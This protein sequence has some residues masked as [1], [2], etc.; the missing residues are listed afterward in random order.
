MT[1]KLLNVILLVI[2][3]SV[4]AFAQYPADPQLLSEINKIKAIDNHAHPLRYVAEGSKPDDE[5][6][7]LP[8]E[9]IDPFP[10]PLR[11]SPENREFIEAW[12]HFYKYNYNDMLQAHTDELLTLKKKVLQQQ[13]QNFPTW[14]LDQLNIETT[15]ANRVAMGTGLMAPRFRWVSF[16]DALL[17]PL[18]NEIAK[19]SNRDYAGFYP[20]EEKLLK[21]YLG[22]LGLNR[23]PATLNEYETKVVTATLERQKAQGVIA[24]KY[25]AA[26]LRLLD[27]EK[28]DPST[29]RA[30]YERFHSGG[31]APPT[32]HKALQD[33]L[34]YYI[35]KEA[36]R[37]GLGSHLHLSGGGGRY[38]APSGRHL[39]LV[40]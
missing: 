23:L 7:A 24:L 16:V 18:N 8:L 5:D 27:F 3:V 30:T 35:A 9:A 21:R 1:A 2:L 39:S 19:K 17:F 20:G 10:P 29:A 12:K 13:G 33:Y 15:F 4:P 6:D 34:F 31:V 37:L 22:E 36:G 28:S 32:D 11:L 14:V 40:G 25:E 26:Y 38:Y